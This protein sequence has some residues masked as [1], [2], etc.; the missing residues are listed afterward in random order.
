MI[1]HRLLRYD[2]SLPFFSQVQWKNELKGFS[3]WIFFY[4]L[5]S[6]PHLEEIKTETRKSLWRDKRKKNQ[7][8]LLGRN[9]NASGNRVE[10]EEIKRNTNSTFV[11][12]SFS[13]MEKKFRLELQLQAPSHFPAN[14][15]IRGTV[16]D[17]G[18]QQREHPPC[19][20]GSSTEAVSRALRDADNARRTTFAVPLPSSHLSTH[21]PCSQCH[22]SLFGQQ[23]GHFTGIMA[24]KKTIYFPDCCH[25]HM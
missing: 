3:S 5:F 10:W 4:F 25:G 2:F 8:L 22:R 7:I 21:F 12:G 6:P 11:F 15:S 23:R 19:E 18:L 20:A 13:Q 1:F 17:G 9:V 16:F 14:S 24:F